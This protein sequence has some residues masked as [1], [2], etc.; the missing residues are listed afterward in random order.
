MSKLV[1]SEMP[2]VPAGYTPS[3]GLPG[4]DIPQP[5]GIYSPALVP[6][7]V[8]PTD[9]ESALESFGQ[10][11]ATLARRH[12][13]AALAARAKADGVFSSSWF[14]SA[15][16]AAAEHYR[17]EQA[18]HMRIV[19]QLHTASEIVKRVAPIIRLAK[20]KMFDANTDAHN[21]IDQL[22]KSKTVV[23]TAAIGPILGRY[24]TMTVSYGA[25]LQTTVGREF[26]VYFAKYGTPPPLAPGGKPDDDPYSD[27]LS[28]TEPV[29][30]APVGGTP[31]AQPVSQ[32]SSPWDD[33]LSP[34]DVVPTPSPARRPTVPQ[35]PQL[36]QLPS[37][38][39]GL[40]DP[41]K[42]LT[43][44]G[45]PLTSL[46]RGAGLPQ[47]PGEAGKLL[48]PQLLNQQLRAVTALGEPFARGFNAGAAAVQPL[49]TGAPSAPAMPL[50]APQAVASPA[51]HA[52]SMVPQTA[53]VTPA[54]VASTG[55]PVTPMSPYGAVMPPTA[56]GGASVGGP[57]PVA[58]GAPVAPAAAAAS[59][60][61]VPAAIREATVTRVKR[62][63]ATSDLD[64]A[65]AV[66][67]DL[68][69]ASSVTYPGLEWAVGVARG[70][71]GVPEFWIASNEGASYIPA[72]VY[73]PRTMPLVRGMDPD[74]DARWFGWF[75]PAQTVWRS[76]TS[77]GLTVSA[78]AT[79]W[80]TP[81]EQ[82]VENVPALASGVMPR[83]G[84]PA[85]ADAATASKKRSHRLET[86]ADAIWLQLQHAERPVMED[87]CR[88]LIERIAFAEPA[89]SATAQGVARMII[90]GGWPDAVEWA[91]LAEEYQRAMLMAGAQRPG[92]FGIEDPEQLVAYQADFINCRRLEALLAWERGDL[93][94]LL[95]AALV[96]G[97]DLSL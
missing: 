6:P 81:G 54:P 87:Y 20:R 67:A 82:V 70:P 71:A 91:A 16:N 39:G 25:E 51:V 65:R 75:D 7:G 73:L 40:G 66:V 88:G 33:A 28:P 48:Q 79:T 62:D 31:P 63:V 49:V 90:G 21:E 92:L 55:A 41:M 26:G 52:P 19:D 42:M 94:D 77:R 85:E 84:G 27:S 24:Q 30:E 57:A 64:T 78:I 68:A 36:P 5:T 3:V 43:G 96:A 12:E 53:P 69:A 9:S 22:L 17:R 37:G 56:A 95:Y 83:E 74:F 50:S 61:V 2:S 29:D 23:A 93:G 14:G 47:L 38:G 80:A 44:A 97:I 1:S 72:G 13:D 46:F 45:N 76:L 59:P 15:A 8:W 32:P 58:A 34:S 35:L 11:L 18:L 86:L 4:S 10:E 89:L 60:G